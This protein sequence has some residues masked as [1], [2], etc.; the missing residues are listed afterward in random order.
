MSIYDRL[1]CFC[2]ACFISGI[3]TGMAFF[4]FNVFKLAFQ[5]FVEAFKP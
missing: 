5:M 1:G 4:V 2:L 3:A